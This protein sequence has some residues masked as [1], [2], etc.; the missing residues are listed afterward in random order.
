[1]PGEADRFLVELATGDDAPSVHE[2]T[3]SLLYEADGPGELDCG[4]VSLELLKS[5]L[6]KPPKVPRFSV[7]P[8]QI[9]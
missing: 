5:D 4:S 6:M 3:V 7:L 8:G 2:F 1:M 9:V